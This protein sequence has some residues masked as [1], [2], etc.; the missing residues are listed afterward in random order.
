MTTA[1]ATPL[2]S[3]SSLTKRYGDVTA[4][5]I[6][7]LSVPRGITGLL[8]PNGAG[9]TTLLGLLLGLHPPD[10]GRISVL[11]LD[12][13]V[14]GAEVRARVGYG[15]EHRR[16]PAD[17][18]AVDFV[19][20][21]AEVHGL[22]P[23]EA[24]ARASDALWLVELGEERS[25][26]LGTM[27]TG[28]L[29]R[30]KLAQ[31]IAHDPAVVFLDEPTDG[32]DPLQR[33]AMLDLIRRIGDEFSTSILLSSHLLA[34][35]ERVCDGAVILD[36]GRVLRAGALADLRAGAPGLVVELND[37]AA[38]GRVAARLRAAGCAVDEEGAQLTVVSDEDTA[39]L[40]RDALIAC[41]TP[42]RRL[43]ERATRLEDVFLETVR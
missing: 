8:G 14:A 12:P 33:D 30:V 10:A 1:D 41:E 13:A 36:G 31:A 9:K 24:V 15:P 28:Q 18:R 34:E 19:R 29:Q 38:A 17:L 42:V 32:L 40:V 2:L 21:M 7:A 20:H 6:D 27:S 35:V 5:D 26:P 16:V 3:V 37:A 22:P 43:Q 25:R 39:R 4:L 23:G 11:G